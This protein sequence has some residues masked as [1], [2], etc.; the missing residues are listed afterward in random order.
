MRTR[1]KDLR[2]KPRSVYLF[3]NSHHSCRP[4]ASSAGCVS[5]AL[6]P[7]VQSLAHSYDLGHSSCPEV[8]IA[9]PETFLAPLPSALSGLLR[10]WQ[11]QVLKQRL[12]LCLSTSGRQLCSLSLAGS[13]RN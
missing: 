5:A 1:I 9:R 7:Y 13:D 2:R 10:R 8:N 4:P 12:A 6:R 11:C 3:W